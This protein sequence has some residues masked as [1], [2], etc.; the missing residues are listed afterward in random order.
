MTKQNY[1]GYMN[2][3]EDINN[4]LSKCEKDGTKFAINFQSS[5][6][7]ANKNGSLT[8]QELMKIRRELDK[9][10]E[11]FD[12]NCI[13][14][15]K[16]YIAGI[17]CIVTLEEINCFIRKNDHIDADTHNKFLS[18]YNEIEKRTYHVQKYE[19]RIS[20]ESFNKDKEKFFRDHFKES[21]ID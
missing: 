3:L 4:K 20:K 6:I 16:W 1:D 9:S 13:C 12:D 17:E 7:Q 21:K 8:D 15:F 11:F 14:K 5:I 19:K 18:L 2:V 10:I